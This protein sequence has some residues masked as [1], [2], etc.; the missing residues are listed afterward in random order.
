M[1]WHKPIWVLFGEILEMTLE[2]NW[3]LFFLTIEFCLL[4]LFLPKPLASFY[5]C[6]IS[7]DGIWFPSGIYYDSV[8]EDRVEV[9]KH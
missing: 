3:E 7:K 5:V 8:L 2:K 1:S 4:P 9:D 6:I